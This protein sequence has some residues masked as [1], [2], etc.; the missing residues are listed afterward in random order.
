MHH[1]MQYVYEMCL[2]KQTKK[3][4]FICEKKSA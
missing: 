1:V 4:A 2:Q 3:N